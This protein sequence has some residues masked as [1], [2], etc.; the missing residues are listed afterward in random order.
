MATMSKAEIRAQLDQQMQRLSTLK[1]G[2]PEARAVYDR[3]IKN[4]QLLGLSGS[5]TLKEVYAEA[6]K[7][8]PTQAPAPTTP[9]PAPTASEPEIVNAKTQKQLLGNEMEMADW[10]AQRNV[11]LG[12][13]GTQ[14]NPFGTQTITQDENGNIIQTSNLSANQQKILDQ[15]E[16]LTQTGQGLAQGTLNQFQAGFNP[17]TAQRVTTGDLEADR[18]RIENEVFGRLTRGL[19]EQ[20]ANERQQMEQTLRNRGIP[21]GSK[22][23]NDQMAEFDKRYDTQI[24]NARATAAQL[25]GE[26]YSRNFGINEQLIANQ[27]SQGQAIRNQNLGEASALQGMGTGLMTPQFQGYQGTSI[28][29]TSPTDVYGQIKNTALT[30]QQI[31][32]EKAMHAQTIA[33]QN[34][35]L[36]Q[37]MALANRPSGGGSS[38]PSVIEG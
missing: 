10:E 28:D 15:G 1:Q 18:A 20:K 34:K 33:Q 27:I 13:A 12:T 36:A 14:V 19:A 9:A 22:Q 29:T 32:A 5:A 17:N 7:R 37:Q 35:A 6:T 8:Y 23:F 26:E 3:I 30:K 38:A 11:K 21:L 2:S 31:E 4:R 16:S 25:G 24:A